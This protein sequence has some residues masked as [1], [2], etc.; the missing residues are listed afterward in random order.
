MN[1]DWIIQK[2]IISECYPLKDKV[3]VDKMYID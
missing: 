3:A 1:D 2:K